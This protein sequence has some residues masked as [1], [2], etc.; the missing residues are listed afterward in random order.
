[1]RSSKNSNTAERERSKKLHQL[2]DARLQQFPNESYDQRFR[3]VANSEEGK[4]LFA[5]M[6]VA[7][8]DAVPVQSPRHAALLGRTWPIPDAE[9]KRLWISKFGAL[10]GGPQSPSYPSEQEEQRQTA[11]AA[12]KITDE[13]KLK[14]EGRVGFLDEVARLMSEGRN[15]DQAWA[16]A[17]ST[18]PGKEYYAQWAR[19]AAQVKSGP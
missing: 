6:H 8:E 4:E 7:N 3:A 2:M 16:E 1:M 15:R 5:A 14:E 11:K 9:F 19:G 13:A 17:S 18:S 10:S 12:G